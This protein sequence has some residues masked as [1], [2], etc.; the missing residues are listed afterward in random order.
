MHKCYHIFFFNF[1]VP[2]TN[3]NNATIQSRCFE[4]L[5]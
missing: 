1:I 4:F 3:K 2:E 5:L